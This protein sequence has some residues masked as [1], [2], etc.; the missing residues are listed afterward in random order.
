MKDKKELKEVRFDATELILRDNLV[1]GAI[2][3]QKIAELNRNIIF[4]GNTMVEGA[5]FGQRIEVR[6]PEV[7]IQGS[8]FAKNELYIAG[9]V[10]GDVMFQKT[11][12][13][14][15]SVV[16]RA[17]NAKPLFCSD[18]NAKSVALRNAYVAGSIYADEI[19]LENCVVVG[20]V[21]ATQEAVI[22][23][24]IVGTFNTPRVK[25]DGT[26]QLLLPSAF[27]IEAPET[28]PNTRLFNLALADL[29][30]LYRGV[31]QDPQSGRIPMNLETDEVRSNLSSE[32]V[33]RTLRSF[34]VVGKVL[35]ADMVDTD[36]FQNHFL[37]TAA[38]LGPQLLKTY[39]LGT[40]A[41]GSPAR[42]DAVS[43]RDFMFDIIAGKTEPRELS[44]TF[45]L[46]DVAR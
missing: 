21:F 12:G 37:L 20:G 31:E 6:G 3:P 42:L 38:A 25:L 13:S 2:L 22:S 10:K 18:I 14:A 9:D 30:S 33:Q 4:D 16:S 15:G 17:N 28:T 35:A 26:V 1:R 24:C 41:D 8:V 43:I 11:V 23:N 7:E 5:V 45:S 27:T 46:A 29:G 36:R 19:T 44:A 40:R 34:T 39:D 32:E